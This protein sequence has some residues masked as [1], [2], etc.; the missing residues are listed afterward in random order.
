MSPLMPLLQTPGG[1]ELLKLPPKY[2]EPHSNKERA[3][4]CEDRRVSGVA[5]E[6]TKGNR[7][8]DSIVVI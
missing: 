8:E 5:V 1:E 6:Q 3:W 4:R 7:L 2:D